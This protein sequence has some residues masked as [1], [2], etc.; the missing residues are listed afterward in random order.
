MVASGVGQIPSILQHERT[1]LLVEPADPRAIA[2]AL[3]CLGADP[4]LR[5]R[6]GTQA[7]AAAVGLYSWDS[8]LAT[9][10]QAL[11]FERSVA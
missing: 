8:V 2:A 4:A 6:L 1:G 9:I 10:R 3:G 7:R 11:T 5:E